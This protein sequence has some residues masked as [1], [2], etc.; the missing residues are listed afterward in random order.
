M[1]NINEVIARLDVIVKQ[2]A[3]TQNRAG[4]FAALYK[5][6]TIAVAEGIQQNAFEDGPRMERLDIAFAKRY[7]EAYDCYYN[8]QHCSAS[9]KF[10]FDSSKLNNLTVLQ[11]LM[12]GIN[13]HI[14]LDLAIAAAL[15]APGVAINALEHD[16]Y[17]INNII[18]S[19]VDD[20]QESLCRIWWPMRL[21][22]K[23]ANGKEEAVLNFSID[24]AR[25]ASWVSAVA[26]ANLTT[27]QQPAYI[28]G[29][30]LNV[31]H[32]GAGIQFPGRWISF[33]LSIVRFTEYND[34]A[35]T[36]SI[37]DTTVV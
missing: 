13:T 5:R 6:M 37:I 32:L 34:I 18:S 36:I 3:A 10:A 2:C 12:L 15:T 1:Q 4:Y 7:I 25:T 33:L 27:A 8:N 22:K 31:Q 17:K 26:L 21:I 35:R 14:N 16:F 9:W 20:V 11:H 24:K 29:M 19:L 23:I 28:Q 30:D